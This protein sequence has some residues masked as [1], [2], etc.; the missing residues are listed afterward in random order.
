MCGPKHVGGPNAKLYEE[1]L[2]PAHNAKIKTN[3]SKPLAHL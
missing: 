2:H 1:K 3:I